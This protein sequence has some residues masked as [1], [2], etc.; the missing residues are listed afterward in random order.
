MAEKEKLMSLNRQRGAYKGQLTRI[1]TFLQKDEKDTIE[2]E[3][4]L[5]SV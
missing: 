1:E 3:T 5:N 4:K 2:Y